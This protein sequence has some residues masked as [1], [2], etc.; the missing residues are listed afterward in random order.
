MSQ[1]YDPM[2]AKLVV[3]DETREK[4]LKKLE[5]KLTEYNVSVLD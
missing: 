4:A 1:Y 3:W 5:G 2:I